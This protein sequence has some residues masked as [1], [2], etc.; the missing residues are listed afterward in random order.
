M[1][2]SR[3]TWRV[4]SLLALGISL[5]MAPPPNSSPPDRI[6]EDWQVVV[7]SPDSNAIGPQITTCV[8]PSS[9]PSAAFL[10]FYLNYRDY[11]DWRPGGLQVKA[12]D[13]VTDPSSSPAVLGSDTQGNEICDTAG[14]TITWTQRISL[15]GGAI[16]YN[17][18]NGQSTTWGQFGQGQGSLGVSFNSSLGDLSAYSPDYSVSKSGV[19]WQSNRVTS[20]TLLQVRYYSGGQ[21]I[22]T[23]S[24]PRTVD[25]TPGN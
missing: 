23:D 10:T 13:A 15:S 20:M 24:S 5:G 1:L 2:P 11:P 19:S 22:W 14:E 9:D 16:N 12:Y 4:V 18:I 17:I 21:L 25:L 3:R 6:E 7:A 8:S